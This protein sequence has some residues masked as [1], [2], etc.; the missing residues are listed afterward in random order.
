MAKKRVAAKRQRR[1]PKSKPVV[2]AKITTRRSPKK[3]NKKPAD[4]K[5]SKPISRPAPAEGTPAPPVP[6]GQPQ[7]FF[8]PKGTTSHFTGDAKAHTK[9]EDQRAHIR[10]KGP[11]TWSARQPGRG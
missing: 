7:P 8:D 9:P 2:R 1:A 4:R 3:A 6:P 10:M 5:R 11:R